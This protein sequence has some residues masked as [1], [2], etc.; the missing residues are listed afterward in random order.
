MGIQ[1][2]ESVTLRHY[3]GCGVSVGAK[4]EP[5]IIFAGYE[6]GERNR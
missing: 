4:Y 5:V 6:S 1:R 3:I 2:D